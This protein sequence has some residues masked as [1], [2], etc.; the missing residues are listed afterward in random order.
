MKLFRTA[1]RLLRPHISNNH[2]AKVLQPDYVGIFA[3]LMVVVFIGVSSLPF[4]YKPF[5]S[6]L[7]F[8]SAITVTDVVTQTNA[9]RAAAGLPALSF[10]EKLSLAA[11]AKGQDM[12]AKQYWAHTAPDGTQPWYFIKNTGYSY[13]VAGENLARDFMETGEMVEAWMESPTH[14]ANIMNNEYQDIGVA[15]INGTLN[16]YETTLVVQMFGTPR[17]TA[18]ARTPATASTSDRAQTTGSV[19]T[20]STNPSPE[21]ASLLDP[22][23]PDLQ[24][25]VVTQAEPNSDTQVL[26]GVVLPQGR[27]FAPPLFQPLQILKAVF[28]AVIM[29]ISFAL[30]YDSFM[31]D[32]RQ[33]IRLVG[34]NLGHVLLF[35]TVA[36]LLISF[37]AGIL[38]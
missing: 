15:V 27:I 24:V 30:I 26:A 37:K 17:N 12:M 9:R 34:H 8:A 38:G 6:V 5:G 11:A 25:S 14:R 3:A 28:L 32:N 23:D 10:N 20:E 18:I 7:G 19:R 4:F 16:G 36:Y 31:V 29:L 33:I 13:T 21:P 2:R 1:N 22:A 35:I